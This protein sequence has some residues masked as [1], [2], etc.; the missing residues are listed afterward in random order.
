MPESVTLVRMQFGSHVYGTNTPA[1]DLDFKAVHLPPARDIL[2]PRFGT[3][4]FPK[5]AAFDIG[6]LPPAK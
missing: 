2:L 3:R 4:S 1:S 5:Y 6:P